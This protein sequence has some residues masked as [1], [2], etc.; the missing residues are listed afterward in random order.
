MISDVDGTV[1]KSDV[2]GHILPKL[3]ISDWCHEGIAKFY[4]EIK[5]NGYEI[6]YLSSRPIG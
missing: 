4:S 3:H 5:A 2:G 6:V 1:T